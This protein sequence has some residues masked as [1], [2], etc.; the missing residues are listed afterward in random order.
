MDFSALGPFRP[1]FPG[2]QPVVLMD[3]AA[4]LLSGIAQITPSLY[5]SSGNV[6]T[7]RRLVRAR[8]ITCIVNA[9]VEITSPRWPDIEYVKVPLPDLPH[10]PLSLYFDLVADKIHQVSW[11]SGRTLVHCV[12]GISRSATLCIAYLMKH[13]QQSLL[14]AHHWVR[15]RR[16][17]IRPNPGFWRQLVD[18][19]RQLFGKNS[20]HMV[21]TPLG[22]VPDIYQRETAVLLLR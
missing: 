17:I 19:E 9:T 8:S 22:M 16:P 12:A 3:E 10:A 20:I 14:T 1:P 15:S 21:P 11:R 2:P 4:G 18:Y 5:L 13:R 7:D 6:A